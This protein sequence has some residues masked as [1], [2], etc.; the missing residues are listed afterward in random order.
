MSNVALITGS[1]RG[2]GLAIAR[3]LAQDGYHIAL[4][5]RHMTADVQTQLD[6]FRA[7][8]VRAAFY[9]CDVADAAAGAIC[10]QLLM[11]N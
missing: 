5:A 1:S 9:T 11:L 8:G 2:I 7:A 6:A 4:N 3:R 10:T